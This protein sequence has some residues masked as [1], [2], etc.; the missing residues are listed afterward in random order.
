MDQYGD[1][2]PAKIFNGL[3]A[4]FPFALKSSCKLQLPLN[5]GSY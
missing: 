3:A 5:S 4:L 1:P 2:F